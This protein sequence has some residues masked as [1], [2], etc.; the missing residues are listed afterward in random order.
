MAPRRCCP[1][2]WQTMPDAPE[3]PS[4]Q[5]L[6]GLRDIHLPATSRIGATTPILVS[7]A[8]LLALALALVGR[9]HRRYPLRRA[10]LTELASGQALA[11]ELRLAAQAALLRRVARSLSNEPGAAGFDHRAGGAAWLGMLD[12]LFATSF[13]SQGDGQ[14]FGEALYWPRAAGSAAIDATLRRLLGGLRR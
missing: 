7:G 4:P 8:L 3:T 9:L 6:V 2:C 11:P 5:T 14:V 13:F 12:Q 10:A 1:S